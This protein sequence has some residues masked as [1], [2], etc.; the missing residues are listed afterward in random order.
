M[1]RTI[2]DLVHRLE[3]QGD[4]IIA[5]INETCASGF[6]LKRI[7][8]RGMVV[9]I[10]FEKGYIP[11]TFVLDVRQYIPGEGYRLGRRILRRLEGAIHGKQGQERKVRSLR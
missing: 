3:A 7:E 4:D 11:R 6:I 1:A 9:T 5:E 2:G 8:R 10:Y